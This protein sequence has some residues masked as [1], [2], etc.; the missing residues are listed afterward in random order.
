MYNS[1]IKPLLFRMDAEKAHKFTVN[2]FAAGLAIPG[3][4]SLMRKK[5]GTIE[6]EK[7]QREFWGLQFPNPVGL[8]A[9]F[10]KDGKYYRQMAALGFGFI[11]IGTV[12]PLPQSGNPKP[13]LFRLPHDEAL[14]N[15]M[16]FNNDGVDAM[17]D[18]LKRREKRDYILA[19]NIGKNKDTPNDKAVEDYLICFRKLHELVDMFVLNVSSPNTPGLRDLQE[20]EPLYEMLARVKEENEKYTHSKPILL[21]IAPDLSDAQ[22]DGVIK[23]VQDVGI[24]GI[25]ATNTTIA[26]EN[27]KTDTTQI[28]KI[29]NGGLS[30]LP[31][32][33]KSRKF[34][35]YLKQNIQVPIISV[36]GI[37]DV[38]EALWRL[39][40]GADLI[41]VYSGLIYQGPDYVAKINKRIAQK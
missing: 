29:G 35:T 39:E 30:G 14:I 8:A 2:M 13:R 11:E 20:E 31:L 19:A 7:L 1:L 23:N 10:D 26:R 27:L 38:E 34:L 36:G 22:L 5:Y 9:G 24:D 41:Q 25:I 32:K 15:R 28:K 21:K 6:D 12:T 17:V 18:R 16:G 37:Y 40:A 33:E 3:I 4:N